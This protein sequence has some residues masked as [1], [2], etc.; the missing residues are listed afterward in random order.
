[1]Q[2]HVPLANKAVA[3]AGLLLLSGPAV[4]DAAE[5]KQ[6]TEQAWDDYVQTANSR[7]QERLR[8]GASFLWVDE[9]PERISQVRAGEIVVAPIGE[10]NPQRVTHGL[11]H[12]WVGA[13]FVPNAT[14]EDIFAVVKDYN[15]YKD[16]YKPLVIDSKSLGANGSD[17]RFSLLMQNQS[18]F[19]KNALASEWNDSYFRVDD[20][21]WYDMAYSTRVE[22]IQA[23]GSPAEHKLPPG[24]GS[25]YIWR[26]YSF[27]RFESRDGG[28]YIELEV[29]GLSRDIPFALRC[30][31]DPIVRRVSRGSLVTSLKETRTA[32]T[33]FR[34]EGVSAPVTSAGIHQSSDHR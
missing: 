9:S 29:I 32:V 34:A 24:A 19:A 27:S 3:V 7:M 17:N 16:F 31:I 23:Y 14:L 20:R 26:L 15:K 33:S 25:G 5:L 18:L 8:P 28:V 21:R 6:E 12:H 30:L 10:H 4:L 13:A 22:E 2:T 11:I 1:M